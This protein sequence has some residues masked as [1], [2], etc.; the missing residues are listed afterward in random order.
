VRLRCRFPEAK[1]DESSKGPPASCGPRTHAG[2]GGAHGFVA[3]APLLLLPVASPAP[4]RLLLRPRRRR[5]RRGW[6]RRRRRLEADRRRSLRRRASRPRSPPPLRRPPPL[7]GTVPRLAF[8]FVVTWDAHHDSVY[9]VCSQPNRP[10]TL[11]LLLT[12]L[13]RFLFIGWRFVCVC[14]RARARSNT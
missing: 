11:S 14:A 1:G 7:T 5:R 4:T 13:S 8:H 12:E 10:Q 6:R 9:L 2:G 3:V